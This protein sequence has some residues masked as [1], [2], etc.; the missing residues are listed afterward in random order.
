M[1][2]G[3]LPQ[4]SRKLAAR[5]CFGWN[6]SILCSAISDGGAAR[7]RNGSSASPSD[8]QMTRRSHVACP[9][10]RTLNLQAALAILLAICAGS[11]L[12]ADSSWPEALGRMPLQT[13]VTQ[14]NRTN[15]ADILLNSFQSTS[16]VKALIFMPGATDEFYMF[17]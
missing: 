3:P 12:G 7:F 1:K 13:K 6:N 16:L 9:T 17:R 10:L 4:A 11:S 5:C 8:H 2:P 14:L 15:C